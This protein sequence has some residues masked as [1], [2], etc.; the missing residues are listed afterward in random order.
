MSA[1]AFNSGLRVSEVRVDSQR[2]DLTLQ[3]THIEI[4]HIQGIQT[5]AT[6]TQSGE[7]L[8]EN[9]VADVLVTSLQIHK[10]VCRRRL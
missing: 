7:I 1:G 8:T 6:V 10:E 9:S 4:D 5:L 3:G 2:T